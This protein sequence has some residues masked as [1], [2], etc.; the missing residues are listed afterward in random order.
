MANLK[1][2]KKRAKQNAP[3]RA[4]NQSRISEIKTLTKKFFEALS[5]SDFTAARDLARTAESKIARAKGKGVLKGNTA[6]R[7][8][9]K[10]AKRLPSTKMA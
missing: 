2:S 9:S 10:L 3:R 8:I 7:K 5:N 1:S 6:A 4:R